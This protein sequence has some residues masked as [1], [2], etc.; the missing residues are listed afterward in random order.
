MK[1]KIVLIKT[2]VPAK[3]RCFDITAAIDSIKKESININANQ[4]LNL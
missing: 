2:A 3:I 1:K 4:K